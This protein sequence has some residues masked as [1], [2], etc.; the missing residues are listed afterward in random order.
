MQVVPAQQ[1]L[2]PVRQSWPRIWQRQVPI[3]APAGRLQS[4]EPQQSMSRRQLSLS[5]RHWHA[6]LTQS[7]VPQHSRLLVQG[8][9][10]SVVVRAGGRQHLRLMPAGCAP[11]SKPEQQVVAPPSPVGMPPS[12]MEHESPGGMQPGVRHRPLRHS[13]PEQQPSLD[14]HISSSRRQA[15]VP[16]ADIIPIGRLQRAPP[17]QSLSVMHVASRARQAQRPLVQSCQPQQS[18]CAVHI[19]PALRQQ[20][21]VP[22]GCCP[23]VASPQQAWPIVQVR[24]SGRHI[25]PSPA[26]PPSPLTPSRGTSPVVLSPPVPASV[27]SRGTSVPASA[28]I[29][30]H[31]PMVQARPVQHSLFSWQLR[32]SAW[33]AQ[34]P[35]VQSM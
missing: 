4:I 8:T 10:G 28:I 16:D 3:I 13:R 21:L 12:P 19:P 24:P 29:R 1:S 11:H 9:G 35:P 23:Q 30:R 33:Q 2:P 5:R 17:Q 20:V 18:V 31:T 25:P 26:S 14:V 22:P 27:P 6:P 7:T 34:R 32:P 15:Q